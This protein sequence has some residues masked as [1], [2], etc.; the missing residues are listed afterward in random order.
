MSHNKALRDVLA[1]FKKGE[2]YRTNVSRGWSTS[3]GTLYHDSNAIILHPWTFNLAQHRH[4]NRVFRLMRIPIVIDYHPK[5]DGYRVRTPLGDKIY[6][7]ATR[8]R[9]Q[10]LLS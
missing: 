8:V 4:L 9:L 6:I 7:C 10:D 2:S 1:A 5:T 3:D